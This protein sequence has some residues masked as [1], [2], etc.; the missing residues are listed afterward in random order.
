MGECI[1][2]EWPAKWMVVH[3]GS[4][5]YNTVGLALHA[6]VFSG[7]RAFLFVA[8]G[9]VSVSEDGIVAAMHLGTTGELGDG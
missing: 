1:C 8:D 3:T 6:G 2:F 4:T 7:G 9:L 5:K